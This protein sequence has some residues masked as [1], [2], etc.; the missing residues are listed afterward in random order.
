MSFFNTIDYLKHGTVS[1]QEACRVL[2]S[3][4]I[5]RKLQDFSPILAGTIPI[6]IDIENSDLDILCHYTDAN[7]FADILTAN[8]RYYSDFKISQTTIN[9]IETIIATFYCDSFEIEV[10]GQP[11]PVC[12][13]A[14]YRHMLI[15]HEII[16]K[17]GDT[18]RQE[19]IALKKAGYKTEPAFATLLGLKGDPY[20]ALLH[21]TIR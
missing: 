1:Q 5:M 17:H 8:F 19:I 7:T 21:Y 3:H 2:S 6:N 18:F 15:E 9:Y 16:L 10:F 11:L 4:G 13:Q 14:G 20:N 12:E